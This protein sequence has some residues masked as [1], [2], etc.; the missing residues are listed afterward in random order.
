MNEEGKEEIAGEMDTRGA[1]KNEEERRE[2]LNKK[3][4]DEG[5]NEEERGW[6]DG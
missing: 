4:R 5:K 2:E 6:T 3:E 1:G